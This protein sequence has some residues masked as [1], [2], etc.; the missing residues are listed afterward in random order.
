MYW[1]MRIER[2]VSLEGAGGVPYAL[3]LLLFYR[4]GHEGK[5]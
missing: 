1:F 5:C 4:W 3:I 2:T